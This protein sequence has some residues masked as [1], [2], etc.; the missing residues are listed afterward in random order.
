MKLVVRKLT[1]FCILLV[2]VTFAVQARGYRKGQFVL[3]VAAGAASYHGDLAQKYF[4]AN[5]T[6]LMVGLFSRYSI[7]PY[8]DWRNQA[9][10]GQIQ[11]DDAKSS[12][13][14]ER[15]LNFKTN[16]YEFASTFEFN[17]LSY[18]INRSNREMD[19]S[20]YVF[21]GI[22]VFYYDPKASYNGNEVGL[23]NLQ[24]ENVNYSLLQPNIPFG[25]GLKFAWTD[26]VELGFEVGYRRLFT[27]YL[28]DVSKTYPSFSQLENDRGLASAQASHAQTYNGDLPAEPNSMRGD[29]HI[30]DSYVFANLTFTFRFFP[31][32]DCGTF[33]R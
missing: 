30:T 15:N 11:A 20:P 9:S 16:I 33:G 26:R 21:A 1:L 19:F 17:F 5:S 14:Q 3:G 24:T 6:G 28:D 23:K 10:F 27:D 25:M 4:N 22:G 8:F 7:S 12:F 32:D 31:K 29:N 13:Y 2:C 18:G